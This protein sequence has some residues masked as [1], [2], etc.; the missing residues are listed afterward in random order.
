MKILIAD[1]T[2]EVVDAFSNA[3]R[4]LGH[5]PV[6]CRTLKETEA[7]ISDVSSG[8]EI[9]FIDNHF[10]NEGFGAER[11]REFREQKPDMDIVITTKYPIKPELVAEIIVLQVGFFKKH[12][13]DSSHLEAEIC[14]RINMRRARAE[15]VAR[16][17]SAL[18]KA[19]GEGGEGI[20]RILTL[21]LAKKKP[22][23]KMVS[24]S[25]ANRRVI[26]PRFEKFMTVQIG[27]ETKISQTFE[28][29]CENQ[30]KAATHF[31]LGLGLNESSAFFGTKL[32]SEIKTQLKSL[33]SIEETRSI[34]GTYALGQTLKLSDQD[35]KINIRRREYFR[36]VEHQVFLAKIQSEC[37][38]CA[39]SETIEVN[40][41]VPSAIVEV[42]AAFDK[43]GFKVPG[44]DGR[45]GH[46]ELTPI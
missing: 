39:R 34:K 30:T 41:Y 40:V 16:R 14:Q 9:A 4:R 24:L 33:F 37:R 28:F 31:Q 29:N 1:D 45:E 36:G 21:G 27:Q 26:F 12:T 7:I 46:V 44:E 23:F 13:I 2:P 35:Q 10:K 15:G 17:I 3:I 18:Q 42:S 8:L 25:N 20:L 22:P 43:M 6:G 38:S 32:G 19:A 11:V 5:S